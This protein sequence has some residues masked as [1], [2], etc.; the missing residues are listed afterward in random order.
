MEVHGGTWQYKNRLN[1]TFWYV[2]E[3]SDPYSSI[4][5]LLD[6]LLQCCTADSAVLKTSASNHTN[7]RS[8]MFQ[9]T[10]AGPALGF[11]TSPAP[12]GGGRLGV[13]CAAAIFGGRGCG[14]R[15]RGWRRCR[16]SR[17]SFCRGVNCVGVG[18]VGD[19]EGTGTD[20]VLVTNLR[21]KGVA[22]A[23]CTWNN[24]NLSIF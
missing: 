20:A 11:V 24:L 4:R 16:G 8:S 3:C 10:A 7:A 14:F 6:S 12:F 15:R 17:G 22:A 13:C 9:S 21:N 19:P 18:V 5:V 1:R 23:V 2:L